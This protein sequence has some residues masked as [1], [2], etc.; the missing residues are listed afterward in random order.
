MTCKKCG[1]YGFVQVDDGPMGIPQA[2]PCS[3][4]VDKELN[5]QAEKCWQNLSSII[6][7]KKSQLQ[8]FLEKD[9]I[10]NADKSTL[11]THVRTALWQA[12]SPRRFVKVVNDATLMS[13]WLSNLSK[14]DSEIYDPDF[15]RDI[16]AATLEDLAESPSLLIIRLGIKMARN[17]AMPEVLTETIE[18]RAHLN[19]PTW[20]VVEPDK[21]LEEGHLAW[22]RSVEDAID[23]WDIVALVKVKS[24]KTE[25]K[26]EDTKG[27]GK[28]RFSL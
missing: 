6:P 10:V 19:K 7:R 3:C 21:P 23:G 8:K 5:V 18:L 25:Y 22:S 20:L 9:A 13:A 2:V 17:S 15:K 28:R 14:A 1:G 26:K 16:R 12:R 24:T 11:A 4:R 27:K